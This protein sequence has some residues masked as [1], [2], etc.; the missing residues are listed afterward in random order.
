MDSSTE[1]EGPVLSVQERGDER[2][3]I[4]VKA[5]RSSS[6]PANKKRKVEI[7][8]PVSIQEPIPGPISRSYRDRMIQ[9]TSKEDAIA[10]SFQQEVKDSKLPPAKE[11]PGDLR[12]ELWLLWFGAA[13]TYAVCQCCRKVVISRFPEESNLQGFEASHIFPRNKGGPPDFYNMV[14]LC[15]YCNRKCSTKHLFFYA[16]DKH[17]IALWNFKRFKTF[18]LI[19]LE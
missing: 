13:L 18:L 16:W 5:K 17:K 6:K 1:S 12:D 11:F 15:G 19:K 10:A 3:E 8:V 14:P 9:D 2:S 4:A 7:P